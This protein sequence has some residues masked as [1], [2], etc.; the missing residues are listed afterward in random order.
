DFHD[1]VVCQQTNKVQSVDA[2]SP[3]SL[4]F[5]LS[6]VDAMGNH[7]TSDGKT[8]YV[9]LLNKKKKVVAK[10]YIMQGLEGRMFHGEPITADERRV[11]IK[12][13]VDETCDVYI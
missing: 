13:I 11:Q 9:N 2:S 1:Y 4:A 10:G 7:E 3:T 6:V 5:P 12:T 8:Q